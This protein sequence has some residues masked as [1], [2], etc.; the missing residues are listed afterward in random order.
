MLLTSNPLSS[1]T[2]AGSVANVSEAYV[3]FPEAQL[4]AQ[5]A[6]FDLELQQPAASTKLSASRPAFRSILGSCGHE[7]AGDGP[8]DGGVDLVYCL[9]QVDRRHTTY[10]ARGL[11]R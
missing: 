3:F 4:C 9:H 5:L 10:T 11:V 6:L 7:G 8:T 2:H 1:K